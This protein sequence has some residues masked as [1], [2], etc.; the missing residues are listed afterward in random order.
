[1]NSEKE[2]KML[3]PILLPIAMSAIGSPPQPITVI[4]SAPS[5]AIPL[6]GYDLTKARDV[7]RL[8]LRI[9][10][11]ARSVCD[12]GYR[13]EMYLEMAAC[14]RT[15]IDDANAQLGRIRMVQSSASTAAAIAITA[16]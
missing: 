6:A 11:A 9:H 4:D 15:A 12:I 2:A 7:Q 5:V 16:K 1:V 10:S 13:G 3:M 8:N 14:V